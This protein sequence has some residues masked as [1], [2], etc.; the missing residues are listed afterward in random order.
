MFRAVTARESPIRRC[1][2]PPASASR[3]LA[4]S[5][6]RAGTPLVG[7]CRRAGARP[8]QR[9][10][11]GRAIRPRAA[12]GSPRCA[13]GIVCYVPSCSPETPLI[14]RCRGHSGPATFKRPDPEIAAPAIPRTGRVSR[15]GSPAAAA[16]ETRSRCPPLAQRQRSRQHDAARDVE[17][18]PALKPEMNAG[19]GG[20][21]L[22]NTRDSELGDGN[23]VQ[24]S[25]GRSRREPCR[26]SR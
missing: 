11:G 1:A 10:P 24:A 8:L 19:L 18:S 23:A 22:A 2:T 7:R 6:T 3:I 21:V 4:A 12:G 20:H 14:A 13:S 25:D 5:G 9:R 17:H 16:I 26:L 15:A